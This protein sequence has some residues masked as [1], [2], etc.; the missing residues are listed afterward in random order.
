MDALVSPDQAFEDEFADTQLNVVENAEPDDDLPSEE[1]SPD[2]QFT[3]TVV[4]FTW[5]VEPEVD[6]APLDA[7]ANDE[8]TR[9]VI[10][11]VRRAEP[12]RTPPPAATPIVD[13][14]A[15]TVVERVRFIEPEETPETAPASL[16]TQFA[17]TL[18]E[19]SITFDAE[20]S[21]SAIDEPATDAF[22]GAT[23]EPFGVSAAEAVP[24]PPK[25]LETD[26]FV[27]TVVQSI[28]IAEPEVAPAPFNEPD[29]DDFTKTIVDS[30]RLID[31]VAEVAE[32]TLTLAPVGDIHVEPEPEAPSIIDL[33]PEPPRSFPVLEPL[34]DLTEQPAHVSANAL[35]QQLAAIT[36]SPSKPAHPIDIEIEVTPEP[37]IEADAEHA[38]P[39]RPGPGATPDDLALDIDTEPTPEAEPVLELQELP[40]PRRWPWILGGGVAACLLAAQ[41]IVHFRVELSVLMP[42]SKPALVAM[43]EVL[44]CKLPLPSQ[45]DLI[46]IETSDLSPGPEGAGHLQ[47]AATLRNR[48]PYGQAW[49]NLELTLTD[50]ADKA[51]VR[52]SLAPPEYLPPGSKPEEGFP[53]RSEQSVHLDMKAPGVP[54]VGYRLYVF[55]P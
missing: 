29:T 28:R 2:D 27:A 46:G 1:S 35:L 18:V 9:T 51:L 50:A 14:F 20:L 30:V 23:M 37:D 13:P 11:P 36:K 31:P 44:D 41:A 25:N 38:P 8:F 47:L 55:Y 53:A 5:Y 12:P 21:P 52:R 15:E 42:R 43:C 48:A 33:V 17:D 10:E 22:H 45:I 24:A 6:E 49:P 34:P 4:G 7:P 3:K 32:S 26:T 54:A 40:A 19:P 16:D 39:T